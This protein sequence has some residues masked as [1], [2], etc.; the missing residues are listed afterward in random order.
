MFR[1]RR[2]FDDTLTADRKVIDLVQKALRAQFSGLDEEEIFR[3]PG[4][5]KNPLKYRFRSILFVAEDVKGALKGFAVL[6]HAPD[7]EFCYLDFI[8][9]GLTKTGRGVGGALYA[10]V[11]EES[12]YLDAKGLLFECLSDDPTLCRDTSILEENRLRLK[13]YERYGAFPIINTRYETP[14]KPDADCPPYLMFDPL[15]KDVRL[16]LERAKKV[17]R[18]IL[19]RKYG[20]KCPPGYIDMVVDSFRDDPVQLRKPR[21]IRET[22][23]AAVKFTLPLEQRIALVVND[24]HEI[25]HVHD[26]GY[27]ESP[28]RIPNI[29]DGVLPLG[30]FHRSPPRYFS[31]R[32]I[33]QVHDNHFVEYLKRVCAMVNRGDSVY[34]Y[35]FP[36]RNRARPP[37]E[38][39]IR[40]GYYCIDTFTP[41]NHNAYIAAK[42]AVDCALTATGF[43]LQGYR[44]AYALVRPPGHH[45]ERK[46][47]GG[48]CYF[49]SSA[50][51]ADYLSRLGR[52]AILDV[53]YHHGNGTQDIFYE[54]DD[55]LTVSIHGHPQFAYPYF[56]GFADEKG[57][58][59]GKGY[60]INYPLPETADGSLYGATLEKALHRI[61]NFRPAFLVVALGFDTAKGDPTGT[62]SL[63]PADFERNGRLIGG[64]GLPVLIVQEGGY[65]IRMLG[66]NARHFFKGLWEAAHR[67]SIPA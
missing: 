46:A 65:R 29:L 33:R 32:F 11:R 21:Y 18:A 31:E 53:D 27:V 41:L 37:R 62:W 42:R 14:L 43:I 15:G 64:M 52:V 9:S 39:P 54:R 1:I 48:F 61:R 23:Q 19:D 20:K 22:V 2:I 17:V 35:V 16:V 38:L 58:G 63:K 30:I 26:R 56:N 44:L 12:V 67:R 28:V 66:S 6:Q 10:R 57:G 50:I 24:N 13:F 3:L 34:P 60:N 47:F 40:A 25:H 4:V 5:L 7:L 45:A 51:A 8:S 55:V 49:N 59:T 36:V